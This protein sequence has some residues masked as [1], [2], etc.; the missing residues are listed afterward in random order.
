MSRIHRPSEAQESFSFQPGFSEPE[1]SKEVPE[2]P[3]VERLE[4]GASPFSGEEIDI[5]ESDEGGAYEQLG[6]RN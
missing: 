6:R 1:K 3:K 4:L 2:K 5:G